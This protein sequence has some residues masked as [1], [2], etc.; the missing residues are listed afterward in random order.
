MVLAS[1]SSGSASRS[2][3]EW[4]W[5]NPGKPGEA[6]FVL[7]NHWEEKLWGLLERSGQL[8][9]GELAVIESGLMEALNKVR[10]AQRTVSGKL[11]SFAPVSLNGS[12]LVSIF[13]LM[14]DNVSRHFIFFALKNLER[15]LLSK[16]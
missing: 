7:S 8:A 11:Q 9:Y 15:I 1:R 4:V 13:F 3:A 14:V 6:R 5:P 12:F 10:V 16:S 2:V